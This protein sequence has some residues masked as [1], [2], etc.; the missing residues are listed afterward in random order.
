MRHTG[1]KRSAKNNPTTFK[2]NK[3]QTED[4]FAFKIC[5]CLKCSCWGKFSNA[6]TLSYRGYN[7]TTFPLYLQMSYKVLLYLLSQTTPNSQIHIQ[8]KARHPL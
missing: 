1:N 4:S 6:Y 7:T 8:R 5:V 3:L 2:K